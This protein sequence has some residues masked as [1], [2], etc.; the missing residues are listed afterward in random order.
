[1]FVVKF[2][3]INVE[4]LTIALGQITFLCLFFS[5]ASLEAISVRIWICLLTLTFIDLCLNHSSE[6]SFWF[7]FNFTTDDVY[8]EK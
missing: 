1:M 4:A 5:F 6:Q 8:T 2:N 7:I 3:I